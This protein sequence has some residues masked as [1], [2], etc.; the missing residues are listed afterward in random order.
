M[1]DT[2]G[3]LLMTS[4]FTGKKFILLLISLSFFF[5]LI[6]ASCEDKPSNYNQRGNY[7]QAGQQEVEDLNSEQKEP[8]GDAVSETE[9]IM[10]IEKGTLDVQW[11]HGS[12]NCNQDANPPIQ[13]HQYSSSVVIM[14]QNK[15]INFE[16]PFMYLIMGS[17]KALL[18]DSGATGNAAQFPIEQIVEAELQRYYGVRRNEIMLVVAH[19][20]G[21]GDHV[22]G[23]GQFQDKPNTVI[24]GTNQQQ[25]SQFFNIDNW[26]VD[27][28][29]YDLGDRMIEIHPIPGHQG[30]DIA[31][32]DPKTQL[33][34]TGDSLYPG[35]IYVN[36]WEVLRTSMQRLAAYFQN[37]PV[38]HVLGAHI[39]MSATPGQDY[40]IGTTFQ[41]NEHVLQLTGATL[42]LL[43][44]ELQNIGPNPMRK[45]TDS[46]IISP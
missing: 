3:L 36:Q 22:A 27:I 18:V 10:G 15:C 16:A 9:E 7:T 46:F 26:P 13:V 30:T 43:N 1:K 33:L 32:Y 11:I 35:R 6:I 20:H 4:I 21:H 14:R 38:A 45:V 2:K 8:I 29:L 37:K 44:T 23:D 25:V 34:L 12:D 24:V 19:S 28:G 39:E 40:P 17:V 31:I 41:P 42:Q 5:S